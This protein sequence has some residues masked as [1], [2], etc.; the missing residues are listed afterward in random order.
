MNLKPGLGG[1]ELIPGVTSPV[2]LNAFIDG[3][4]IRRQFAVPV[5]RDVRVKV[6]PAIAENVL[7]VSRIDNLFVPSQEVKV[8][9]GS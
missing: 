2:H 4:R 5:D 1:F 9:P 7:G 3:H 6:T 8:I